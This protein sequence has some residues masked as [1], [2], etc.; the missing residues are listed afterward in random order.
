[1]YDRPHL[2]DELEGVKVKVPAET[3]VKEPATIR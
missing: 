2:A 1:V 3:R